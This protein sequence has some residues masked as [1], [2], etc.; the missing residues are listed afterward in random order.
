[1]SFLDDIV[2]QIIPG[3]PSVSRV[4][5]GIPALV[6]TTGQRSILIHGS[7]V[8]GL[9]VKSVVRNATVS[10]VIQTGAFAYAFAAGVVTID[11]PAATLVRELVADFNI[12][13]PTDVTDV[14]SIEALKTGSGIL[15]LLAETPLEFETF[16][17]LVQ[18]EQLNFFFDKTDP[19][20]KILTNMFGSRPAPLKIFLFDVFN[21]ADIAADIATNDNGRWYALLT[22][23]TDE[24]T[25][26]IISDYA[27]SVTRLFIYV[28]DDAGRLD[29]IQSSR[30]AA[31]IHDAPDDH[32]EASWMAQ[33]L[34]SE[35][36]A[37]TWKWQNV[38][39][40][41]IANAVA[42]V[43]ALLNVRNKKGQSYVEGNGV[44][45]VDEGITSDPDQNTYIDDRRS[46]DFIQINLNA[47]LLQMFLNAS[48]AG[49]KISYTNAGIAQIGDV[50]ERRLS[51]AGVAK[52]I[53]LV[54]TAEQ[55]ELSSDGAFRFNI[56][57]PTVEDLIANNPNI[58]ATRVL[59]DIKFS[60]IPAGAIHE[61]KPITGRVII[62]EG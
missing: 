51:L 8:S 38:L 62:T 19:E 48:K 53:A 61:V 49:T 16:R 56:K 34:P 18:I 4:G 39:K 36:G 59:P 46:Q 25:Q 10:L 23:A 2:V 42:D 47:D 11:I 50:I 57:L 12:N 13:A 27:D 52:I 14:I 45:Y 29:I 41:Q 28:S 43:N 22:N 37:I 20:F 58:K 9:V 31:L 60:Y 24:T 30:T 26:Q 3:A 32:P 35:P 44:S 21:S 40:G 15:G 5:F 54:E 6:G 7:G 17:E 1:M 33:S 55:A